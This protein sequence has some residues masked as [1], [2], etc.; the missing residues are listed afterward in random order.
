MTDSPVSPAP[1]PTSPLDAE[2]VRADFPILAVGPNTGGPLTFLDS[3]ASA[4]KPNAVLDSL[5]DTYAGAYAN[6]HRGVYA[7]AS[8]ATANF[9]SAREQVRALLNA[10]SPREVIFTRGT[11]EAINLVAYSWGRTNLGP[12]DIVLTTELE[13]HS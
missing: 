3:A 4:M 5:R 12:G 13:H 9:E 6:V 8:T 2:R 7:H 1:A 11:T 10:R